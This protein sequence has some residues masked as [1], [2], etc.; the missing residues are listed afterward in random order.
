MITVTTA[1][2][3]DPDPPG[4]IV[5]WPNGQ[6]YSMQVRAKFGAVP[7]AGLEERQRAFLRP[8]DDVIGLVW[9]GPL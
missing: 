4:S 9:P 3:D 8:G 2:P 1:R 5:P 6:G 7:V